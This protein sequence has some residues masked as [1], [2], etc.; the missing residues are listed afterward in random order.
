MRIGGI[1]PGAK[2]GANKF[3]LPVKNAETVSIPRGTPVVLDVSTTSDAAGDGLEVVLP[4]SAGNVISFGAKFGVLTDTLGA[5]LTGESILFG[6]SSYTL[7]T[8]GT[9]AA[10]TDSW[11]SSASQASG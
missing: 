5:G 3:V 8:R 1:T 11:T 7:I 6:I 10:S 4:S 2:A 9:R